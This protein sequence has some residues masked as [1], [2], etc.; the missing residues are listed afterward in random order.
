MLLGT[1]RSSGRFYVDPEVIV[2]DAKVEPMV[3]PGPMDV[4]DGARSAR[5]SATADS[6]DNKYGDVALRRRDP[7]SLVAHAI[8]APSGGNC[9]PWWFSFRDGKLECHLDEARSTSF[10]NLDRLASYTAIGAAGG[11]TSLSPH[12][13]SGSKLRPTSRA[14][15]RPTSKVAGI[16]LSRKKA[17]SSALFDGIT[18]RATSIASSP[19]AAS[20]T[21]G[22]RAALTE[23]AGD[24]R[25]SIVTDAGKLERMGAILGRA[26]RL[27]FLDRVM[28]SELIKELRWTK[29]E[30]VAT[31][32]GLDLA[33]LEFDRADMAILRILSSW[34]AMDRVAQLGGGRALEQASRKGIAGSSGVALLTVRGANR[35]A[36]ATGGR[37]LQ[38]V[39]LTANSIGTRRASAGS[40]L[41]LRAPRARHAHRLC[42]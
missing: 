18:R 39:W 32:D 25:L 37:A 4:E 20:L 13:P 41:L 34:P 11:R 30:V 2:C 12:G 3:D 14:T 21:P 33:T 8:L 26:D 5:S 6:L 36:Y 10:V 27:R 29:E 1:F 9:Q 31:R 28:H 35:A 40:A 38:R 42:T 15:T 22:E 7:A 17:V 16:H 19:N 24:A 23:A